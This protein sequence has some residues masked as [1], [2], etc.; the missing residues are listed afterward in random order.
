MAAELFRFHRLDPCDV[1]E[2]ISKIQVSSA[3]G[4]SFVGKC[5]LEMQK[6]C[7]DPEVT[8]KEVGSHLDQ[9]K[10]YS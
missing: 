3:A 2:T 8:W 5:N 9:G 6:F 4:P 10:V 7:I 1:C